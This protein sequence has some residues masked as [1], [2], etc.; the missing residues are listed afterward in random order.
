MKP[1][2]PV[3]DFHV[4]LYPDP[5]AQQAVGQLAH[6]FG[7]APAFDGTVEGMKLNLAE[8][9]I[10]GSLNL[11]VAT[12]PSQVDS[13]NDWAAANNQGK[14]YS[15]ATVHPDTPDIPGTLAAARAAGFKGVKLHPEYQA[16]TLDDPRLIP[17]WETCCGLGLFIFLHAG[18]ERVFTPPFHTSPSSIAALIARY[19]GLTLVAAHLGGFQMWDE[20]EEVLIGKK[21][22]LDLSHTF[23]WM[24]DEQIVRMVRKHG[25]DKILFGSDAPWQTPARVLDAFLAQSFTKAEQRQILWENAARLLDLPNP[26][27]ETVPHINTQ[28]QAH[29]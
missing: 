3:F 18:G 22:Y 7:N 24:S 4:H 14:I 6:R 26:I 5:L 11:P 8:S 25:A 19:P 2:F 12:K 10:F 20:S 29:L 27:R 23:F 9:G 17:V 16:F 1:F 21:L 13:I 15:L 28:P